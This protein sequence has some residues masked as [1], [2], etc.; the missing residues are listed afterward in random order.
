MIGCDIIEIDRIKNAIE[1]YGERFI[2]RILTPKEMEIFEKRNRSLQFF[3]VDLRQ[4]S[5]FPRVLK[6]VSVRSCP[7]RI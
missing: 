6:Q 3:L 1:K 7:S 2:N 4:R 5:L